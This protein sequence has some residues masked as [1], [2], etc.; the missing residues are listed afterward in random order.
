MTIIEIQLLLLTAIVVLIGSGAIET[1]RQIRNA[2]QENYQA[3]LARAMTQTD[4]AVIPQ[5]EKVIKACVCGH[6]YTMHW[7]PG[8]PGQGENGG[9]CRSGVEKD[10]AIIYDCDCKQFRPKRGLWPG[11]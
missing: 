7:D 10:G 8:P 9:K 3:S 2:I 1:L 4:I 6:P 5:K 11:E